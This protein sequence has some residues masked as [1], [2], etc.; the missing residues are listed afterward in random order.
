M[1]QRILFYHS[2]GKKIYS[3]DN[4]IKNQIKISNQILII[5]KT[6]FYKTKF[7][8]NKFIYQIDK[9]SKSTKIFG[10]EFV[11]INKKKAYLIINNKQKNLSTQI[12][13]G[14]NNILKLKLKLLDNIININSMFKD[15]QTL[16][17]LSDFSKGFVKNINNI[18]SMFKGCKLLKFLPD[19][20]NWNTKNISNMSKFFYGCSSLKSLPDISN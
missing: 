12:P 2:I 7:N 15:C 17:F 9:K 8:F 13:N 19:I 10:N 11:K 18:E 6:Q 5:N 20:L 1:S 14:K 3:L 16:L 4:N